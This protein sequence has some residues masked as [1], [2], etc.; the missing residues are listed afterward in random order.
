MVQCPPP[1]P[2]EGAGHNQL[3][4]LYRRVGTVWGGRGGGQVASQR[5]LL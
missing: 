5:P 3:G 2:V 4:Q 1:P